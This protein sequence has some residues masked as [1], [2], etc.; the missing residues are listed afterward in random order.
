MT[1]VE[2]LRERLRLYQ[3]LT[4]EQWRKAVEGGMLQRAI[5]DIAADHAAG[6]ISLDEAVAQAEKAADTIA[7]LRI[8]LSFPLEYRLN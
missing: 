2:Y 7:T 1:N 5:S 8:T 6:H 4:P 3:S